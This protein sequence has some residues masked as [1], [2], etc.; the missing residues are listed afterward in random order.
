MKNTLNDLKIICFNVR[1][2]RKHFSDVIKDEVILQADVI[3][4]CETWLKR[5]EN[6]A[7]LQIPSYTSMS[8]IFGSG[9]GVTVFHRNGE[10]FCATES[11]KCQIVVSVQHTNYH[12]PGAICIVSIY[13]SK[14]FD[15]SYVIS[16]LEPILD[17]FDPCLQ[18]N[19]KSPTKYTLFLY[20]IEP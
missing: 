5:G 16:E 19:Y 2:L 1:S 7:D 4:M 17:N 13:L 6:V 9:K 11:E 20:Q 15:L 12:V 8:S 3:C 14:N 18:F 10:F